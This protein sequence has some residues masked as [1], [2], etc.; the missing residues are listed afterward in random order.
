[1]IKATYISN[2]TNSLDATFYFTM[3][4]Y[5]SIIGLEITIIS[6]S[7]NSS[8]IISDL[9]TILYL[10][11]IYL[12]YLSIYILFIIRTYKEASK[13]LEYELQNQKL[14]SL[15]LKEQIK[16]HFIFNSLNII[17]NLYHSDLNKGDYALSLLSKHLR[18]NVNTVKT[19]LISF[20]KEIDNIYNFVELENL[21]VDNKFEVIFNI[22][23]Q[24]FDI[25]ILSLQPFVENSIKYSKVNYKEEGK[26]EI[27]AYKDNSNIIVEI[28]DNGIGFDPNDIKDE[29]C[30][31]RNAKE[32][33]SLLLNANVEINSQINFG[34][35]IKITIPGGQNENNNSR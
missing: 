10:F 19:N 34:T 27:S 6:S 5:F 2:H 17:K 30:G 22:D 32:R 31:I 8:K 25:P 24:D 14:K 33:L 20:D 15:I 11:F 28:N 29:S 12:F 16:P 13:S 9:S 1:M 35:N 21:K 26:I 7:I 3:M 4:I 18:F 23:Y